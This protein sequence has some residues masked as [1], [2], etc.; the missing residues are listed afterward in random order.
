[1]KSQ[2]KL[3]SN[4]GNFQAIEKSD[5]PRTKSKK[6]NYNNMLQE[7]NSDLS[8]TRI[9]D[10]SL[11]N[12]NFKGAKFKSG[13]KS[14]DFPSEN[15]N[16]D[17]I[18]KPKN[19]LKRSDS[20]KLSKESQNDEKVKPETFLD[21]E[22]PIYHPNE[23]QDKVKQIASNII[24]KKSDLNQKKS[25]SKVGGEKIEKNDDK[26]L[27]FKNE[28]RTIISDIFKSQ[29]KNLAE[30]IKTEVKTQVSNAIKSQMKKNDIY[31]I[32]N[33]EDIFVSH[34][35]DINSPR[36]MFSFSDKFINKY[37][38]AGSDFLQHNPN[39]IKKIMTDSV[40]EAIISKNKNINES[41]YT[42]KK[43]QYHDDDY[44][45]DLDKELSGNNDDDKSDLKKNKKSDKRS[46]TENKKS[47]KSNRKKKVKTF[48]VKDDENDI[49][50]P[51]DDDERISTII[52]IEKEYG[53][54]R[55]KSKLYA[56]R[57]DPIKRENRDL[58]RFPC[59][60]YEFDD[61]L[62]NVIKPR[63]QCQ[64]VLH[65]KKD[66]RNPIDRN[67]NMSII[68]EQT[69]NLYDQSLTH[70]LLKFKK[71]YSSGNFSD[72]LQKLKANKKCDLVLFFR[73]NSKGRLKVEN[74]VY[75]YIKYSTGVTL[76]SKVFQGFDLVRIPWIILDDE[77]L[78]E[79]MTDKR[80]KYCYYDRE[81]K[82]QSSYIAT[83]DDIIPIN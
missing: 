76:P 74:Y 13:D 62:V 43:S 40:K 66:N 56:E 80:I 36:D 35:L 72:I 59:W 75:L 9:L 24:Q 49:V 46:K 30:S 69:N 15:E 19:Q 47:E 39:P 81:K 26:N 23:I 21:I 33:V 31:R 54:T 28:I 65:G 58:C 3:N 83:D 71:I 10:K 42:Y 53:I 68:R 38:E 60:R 37:F 17:D 27:I 5:F 61:F 63:Q 12:M 78:F 32:T 73:G 14:Q 52:K 50:Y 4:T 29:A 57:H 34:A 2:E 20:K 6:R 18:F 1:M 77:T 82:I 41:I 44:F 51:S 64:I 8:Q 48:D 45:N 79:I 67:K 11:L 25:D 22:E 55:S 70:H 7:K 16:V